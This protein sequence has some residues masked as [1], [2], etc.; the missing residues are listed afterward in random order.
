MLI[1]TGL[2]V[3]LPKDC[4][5]LIYPRSGL[6]T[7]HNINL[8]NCVGVI[9]SDYRGEIIIALQNTGRKPYVVRN[10]DRVAQG[11]VHHL[12]TIEIQEVDELKSTK[13]G[14]GGFGSTGIQGQAEQGEN[15][16]V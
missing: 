3:E 5:L 14:A 2:S 11:I 6:A 15:V 16:G 8:A 7:T 9:D 12:P 13:R 1:K 10:L 4:V